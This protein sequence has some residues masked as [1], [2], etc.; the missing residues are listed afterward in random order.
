M[1]DRNGISR[2]EQSEVCSKLLI[3]LSRTYYLKFVQT[4]F[5]API[6]GNNQR[7]G[8]RRRDLFGPALLAGHNPN[9]ILHLDINGLRAYATS[10]LHTM[11][12]VPVYIS[13]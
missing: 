12:L 8:I 2:L 4:V 13:P 6:T 1:R 3:N 10:A 11:N 9:N 7:L 5:P